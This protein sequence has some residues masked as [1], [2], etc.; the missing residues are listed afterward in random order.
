MYLVV[1][2]PVCGQKKYKIFLWGDMKALRILSRILVNLV[3]QLCGN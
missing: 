3:Q 2:A 1:I